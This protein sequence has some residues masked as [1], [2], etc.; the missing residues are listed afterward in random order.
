MPHVP[1]LTLM[2][3]PCRCRGYK[4]TKQEPKMPKEAKDNRERVDLTYRNERLPTRKDR[5]GFQERGHMTENSAT[6]Y[7]SEGLRMK[8]STSP[9]SSVSMARRG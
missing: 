1:Q 3:V 4:Q 8:T 5:R 2:R 6:I 9:Y 7:S